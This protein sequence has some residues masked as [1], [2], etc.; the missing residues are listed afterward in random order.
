M[1]SYIVN[2]KHY[3]ALRIEKEFPGQIRINANCNYSFNIYLISENGYSI[4]SNQNKIDYDSIKYIGKQKTSYSDDIRLNP[5]NY[6][7]VLYNTTTTPITIHVNIKENY[8]PPLASGITG[9]SGIPF[10]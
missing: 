7:L 9:T 3:L 1:N 6:Y 8:D 4:L 2:G 10:Y 5:G